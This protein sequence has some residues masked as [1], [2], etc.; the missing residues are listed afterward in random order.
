MEKCV[1]ENNE[2]VS[3]A[4]LK[5]CPCRAGG[6]SAEQTGLSVPLLSTS[7][8]EHCQNKRKKRL[9]ILLFT[10]SFSVEMQT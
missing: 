8:N 1:N 9:A 3:S 7:D 5:K 6:D 2:I 4:V 10:F